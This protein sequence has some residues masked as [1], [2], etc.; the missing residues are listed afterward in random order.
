MTFKEIKEALFILRNINI[1][2]GKEGQAIR[3]AIK[4]LEKQI[5]KKVINIH[6]DEYFC[7]RCSSE[8]NCDQYIVRDK[9]CPNCGQKLYQILSEQW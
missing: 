5:P 1:N 3:T 7:P 6:C 8:N 9:Y 4:A 2:S